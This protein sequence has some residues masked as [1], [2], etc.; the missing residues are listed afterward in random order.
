L[1]LKPH[2]WGT[3]EGRK[4]YEANLARCEYI[5]ARARIKR[6]KDDATQT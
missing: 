4:R 2:M 6:V 3:M 5:V 1:K